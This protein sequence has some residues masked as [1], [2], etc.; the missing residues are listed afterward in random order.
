MRQDALVMAWATLVENS[1]S[2]V[3]NTVWAVVTRSPATA[4]FGA[5]TSGA[6]EDPGSSAC[7]VVA[8]AFFG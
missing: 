1:T 8:L 5:H 2:V 3:S 4:I 6:D 7:S